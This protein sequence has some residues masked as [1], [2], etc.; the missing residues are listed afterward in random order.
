VQ[1]DSLPDHVPSMFVR[2]FNLF[3]SPGTAPTANG[4][5][6][7]AV[8]RVHREPYI[9]CSSTRAADGVT[10]ARSRLQPAQGVRRCRE[11]FQPLH[12]L[13]SVLGED[14]PMIPLELQLPGHNIFRA[15]LDP[16]FSQSDRIGAQ[17]S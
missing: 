17:C 14:R 15:L 5:P 11:L 8:P 6:Q 10:G 12:R 16:L 7:A 13:S 2:D 1:S 3:T 4:Y 9:F